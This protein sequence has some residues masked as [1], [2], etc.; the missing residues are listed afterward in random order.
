MKK[1]LSWWKTYALTVVASATNV[2]FYRRVRERKISEAAGYLAVLAAILWVAPFSVSFFLTVRSGLTRFM[3]GFRAT[4]PPGT[5]FEMKQG[6]LASTLEAPIVVRSGKTALIINTATSTLDLSPDETGFAVFSTSISQ[7][8]EESRTE[9][10]TFAKA[11]DFKL[12]KEEMVDDIV[13]Y[14][15]WAVFLISLAAIAGLAVSIAIG[16]AVSAAL[17]A[18]LLWL[19]LRLLK[20]HWHYRDAYIVALYASTVPI[21]VS[22]LFALA[23]RD[24]GVIPSA[25]YWVLLAFVAYDAWSER[26]ESLPK[27]GA[28]HDQRQ[29]PSGD[30][31]GTPGRSA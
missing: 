19:L 26:G 24:G 28:E 18:L 10:M 5:V 17:H 12:S 9:T 30:R 16:T 6:T 2:A 23:G 27:P 21:A 25:L 13:G 29:D 14:A 31:P 7:K 22:A 8:A 1:F 15:K 11:P 20:R 3:E 4:V